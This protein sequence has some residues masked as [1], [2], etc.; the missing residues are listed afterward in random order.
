VNQNKFPDIEAVQKEL[1]QFSRLEYSGITRRIFKRSLEGNF[2]TLQRGSANAVL[3]REAY[4]KQALA[5]KAFASRPI[6]NPQTDQYHI[7]M[8]PAVL[9]SCYKPA[10]MTVGLRD[11]SA[12]CGAVACFV[13]ARFFLFNFLSRHLL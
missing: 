12:L 5:G 6:E 2:I 10:F 1:F 8:M 9:T 13:F 3:F 7:W 11:S 4:C